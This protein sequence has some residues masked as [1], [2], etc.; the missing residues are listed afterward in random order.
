PEYAYVTA[1]VAHAMPRHAPTGPL[2]GPDV[3]EIGAGF[4][5]TAFYLHRLLRGRYT[6]IDLPVINCLQ[7]YFLAGAFGADAVSLYGESSQDASVSI[8]PTQA[9]D[10]C[11]AVDI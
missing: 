7:G 11:G 8:L 9:I 2:A 1:R 6:I 10:D 5:G 4:G 3:L